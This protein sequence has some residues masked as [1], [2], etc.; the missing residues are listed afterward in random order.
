[1][2]FLTARKQPTYSFSWNFNTSAIAKQGPHLVGNLQC[3]PQS[4]WCDSHNRGTLHTP[5]APLTQPWHEGLSPSCVSCV[6]M[7]HPKPP[8]SPTPS[9][10]HGHHIWRPR[11]LRHLPARPPARSVCAGSRQAETKERSLLALFLCNRDVQGPSDCVR[12]SP[13]GGLLG[14]EGVELMLM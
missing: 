10:T 1:M 3:V 9:P 12:E 2:A 14:S 5:T 13:S 11:S 8:Q 4:S 6:V 7:H